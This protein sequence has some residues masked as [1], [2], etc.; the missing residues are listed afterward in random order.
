MSIRSSIP[1]L[2]DALR[3]SILLG[4][5]GGLVFTGCLPYSCQREANETLFSSDS[6]SRR[7]AQE[8]AVDTLQPGATLTGTKAHPIAYPRT[9]RFLANGRLAASDA[10]RNSLFFFGPESTFRR[11]LTDSAFAVPY[12]IGVRGGEGNS[13]RFPEDTLVVFSAESDRVDFV[14][15]EGRRPA[16]SATIER[17]APETLVYMLA[18]DT[19]LYAKVVGRHT[20]A[21]LARLDETGQPAARIELGGTYWRHAGFLRA[22]GDSLLSLSGFRPVVHRLPSDFSDHTQPD[23]LSLVGFDSPMLERS[24]AY[25]QDDVDK[26]PL[27]SASAAPV[28]DTLF[29]LN[30]RPGWVQIDAY[31]RSGA[32]RR[33]L[34]ERHE[35]GNRNFYPV[36]L[37]VRR[38]NAGY[39]FAVAV[40]SPKPRIELFR[41]RPGP[42]GPT[43]RPD[44]PTAE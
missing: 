32:L 27:L 24:Y 26:P 36:D 44:A 12:L 5:V 9:V 21:I 4:L 31:D 11:E 29:V 8:T 17:P 7:V 30:L 42:S 37:D 1:G 43:S 22:W 40:R 39:Q 13:D 35:A 6:V 19:N 23:S 33:R 20:G 38:T 14:T 3:R 25:A 10:K 28:G 2:S 41:W 15:S 34:V 18:T 16:R